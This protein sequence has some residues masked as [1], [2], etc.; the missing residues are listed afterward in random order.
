[1]ANPEI[2]VGSV[3]DIQSLFIGSKLAESSMLRSTAGV[4]GGYFTYPPTCCLN[5]CILA[6]WNFNHG[7]QQYSFCKAQ[8]VNGVKFCD[9]I[10]KTDVLRHSVK[11]L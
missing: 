1:M 8:Q 5:C 11:N 6:N 10:V 3:L 4:L 9:S 7:I 2:G